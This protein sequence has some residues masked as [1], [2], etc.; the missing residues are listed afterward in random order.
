METMTL[1]EFK[2]MSKPKKKPSKYR[3]VITYVDGHKFDSKTEARR[4]QQLILLQRAG[5]I[6]GLELQPLFELQ[7]KF[8]GADG[9]M[10]RAI[11]YIADFQYLE[12]GRVVV[13]DVK[14]KQTDVFK[15]KKKLFL[16]MYPHLDLR[17]TK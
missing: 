11:T 7:A 6:S 2:A 17:I 16:E 9:K 10:V 15:I 1:E 4:Y 3:N 13:E 8:R 14:G 5:R 12:N